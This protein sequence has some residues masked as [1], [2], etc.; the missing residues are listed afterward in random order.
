MPSR[1]NKTIAVF[2]AAHLALHIACGLMLAVA[3]PWFRPGIR[4]RILQHWS[5]RLLCIFNVKVDIAANDP[6]H[7]LRSGL[8]VTNHISWLDV[9]VL[10]SIV[11]M[12]FVAKAEVR[13]W[14]VFGWLCARA[15][16]LFLERGKA[17]EAARMNV[18]L[19]ELLRQG[20]CLAVF[21]EGTTTDGTRI[22]HFH[23]SLLQPAIDAAAQVHPIAIRYQDEDGSLSMAAAY[24]DEMSFGASMWNIL[25][26]PELHVRLIATPPL[27]ACTLDRR[28]LTKIAHEHI[29]SALQAASSPNFHIPLT[30]A[31]HHESILPPST[32]QES[33]SVRSSPATAA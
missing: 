15:Q 23:S 25:S 32:R 9:F 4:R 11:P 1:F 16:T 19:V 22:A 21:P 7:N 12:R 24:I 27:A 28:S 26:T 17:R 29:G 8:I 30:P 2:R 5:A 14:P 18:Q 33:R 6:L 3:Y 10:N 20:E 31:Q 13:R